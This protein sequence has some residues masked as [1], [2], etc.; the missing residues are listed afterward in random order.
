MLKKAIAVFVTL[1]L[2]V[3][4]LPIPAFSA[5]AATS[6]QTVNIPIQNSG[7][8]IS[9]V[10]YLSPTNTSPEVKFVVEFSN[11]R[12]KLVPLPDGQRLFLDEIQNNLSVLSVNPKN[13]FA[14]EFANQMVNWIK[15]NARALGTFS[16]G[17][18]SYSGL[19]YDIWNVGVG[20]SDPGMVGRDFVYNNTFY[21]EITLPDGQEAHIRGTKAVMKFTTGGF[22]LG[23]YPTKADDGG[24]VYPYSK[25]VATLTITYDGIYVFPN[26]TPKKLTSYYPVIRNKQ[27]SFNVAGKQFSDVLK[28]GVDSFF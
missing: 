26:S 25:I 17:E 1:S 23:G 20:S 22:V 7:S 14:K 28:D 10:A 21:T 16:Y 4:L 9:G 15:S 8:P 11:V 6:T 2:I 13:D 19:P 12:L 5:F 24:I 27:V 18:T 3:S